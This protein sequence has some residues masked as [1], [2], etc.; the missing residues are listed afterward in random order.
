[1]RDSRL[2]AS[3]KARTRI[4]RP[5]PGVTTAELP[6]RKDGQEKSPREHRTG[7]TWA[8]C[9]RPGMAAVTARQQSAA[10]PAGANRGA[11]HSRWRQVRAKIPPLTGWVI[12]GFR[13]T[14]PG[15]GRCCPAYPWSPALPAVFLWKVGGSDAWSDEP[16]RGGDRCRGD[17]AGG[18][19]AG[20]GGRAGALAGGARVR[21]GGLPDP[22]PPGRER[23]APGGVFAHPR[24]N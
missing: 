12:L 11:R 10:L 9:R 7:G 20:H 24:C 17:L 18:R 1:G 5:R 3:R 19:W 4:V 22:R 6:I 21:G 23:L 8:R 2:P 13:A 14:L 16:G 15:A